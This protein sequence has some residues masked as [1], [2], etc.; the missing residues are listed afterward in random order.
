M[1]Q[2]D[3]A[4]AKASPTRYACSK[5]QSLL[6]ALQ[7]PPNCFVITDAAI[8]S[9]AQEWAGHKHELRRLQQGGMPAVALVLPH[10]GRP[11]P[12]MEASEGGPPAG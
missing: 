3:A 10:F 1:L 5:A 4:K 12:E 6:T 11:D 8:W 7:R 9:L 2:G